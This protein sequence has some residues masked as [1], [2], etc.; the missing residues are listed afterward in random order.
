MSDEKPL[1][2]RLRTLGAVCSGIGTLCVGIAALV[3]LFQTNNILERLFRIEEHT[4]RLVEQSQELGEEKKELAVQQVAAATDRDAAIKK[5]PSRP[6]PEGTTRP[7]VYLPD[8]I[9]AD[10]MRKL[11]AARTDDERK[12]ILE[13][14]LKV[15]QPDFRIRRK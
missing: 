8:N 9:R 3:A 5:I 1:R 14:N 13:R 11:R 15:S 7:M 2:E 10:V 6:P 12:A 4:Q